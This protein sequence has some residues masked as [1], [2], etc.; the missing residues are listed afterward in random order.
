ML[1]AIAARDGQILARQQGEQKVILETDCL[2]LVIYGRRRTRGAI[3]HRLDSEGDREYYACLSGVC[4]CF[5][6]S[7]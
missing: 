6:P 7:E 4:F 1:E 5:Q 2:E 3:Y